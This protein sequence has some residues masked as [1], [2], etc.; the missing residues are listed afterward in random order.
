MPSLAE[1]SGEIQQGKLVRGASLESEGSAAESE[2]IVAPFGSGGVV[3]C[4]AATAHLNSSEKTGDGDGEYSCSQCRGPKR[5]RRGSWA[6]TPDQ[7]CID[8]PTNVPT[9]IPHTKT[10]TVT[11]SEKW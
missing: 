2:V 7:K 11:L 3:S 4:L 5:R 9:T 1:T 6:Y 10:H 8:I